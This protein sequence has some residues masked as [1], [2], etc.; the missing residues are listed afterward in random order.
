M[1]WKA[2]ERDVAK[3]FGVPTT[4]EVLQTSGLPQPDGDIA[5]WESEEWDWL[6]IECKRRKTLAV[7]Q[8]VRECEEATDG[9]PFLLVA[10]RWGKGDPLDSYAITTLRHAA[11]HLRR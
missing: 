2:F 8:W 9:A 11:N 5:T 10:K 3:L 7:P 6:H 1:S 4:R